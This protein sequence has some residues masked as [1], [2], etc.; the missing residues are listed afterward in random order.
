MYLPGWDITL[1]SIMSEQGPIREWC[2]H[3]FPLATLE[4]IDALSYYH[5]ENDLQYNTTQGAPY[6]VAVAVRLLYIGADLSELVGVKSER[7][8]LAKNVWLLEKERRMFD[9]RYLMLSGE[10]YCGSS[11]GDSGWGG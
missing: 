1:G 2:R 9:E 3:A 5:V 10:D 8:E 7:H 4:A 11:G 6:L